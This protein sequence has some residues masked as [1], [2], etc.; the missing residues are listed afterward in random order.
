MAHLL[1]VESWVGAMSRLL[2]R[3]I[4]EA[5]HEFTFLTRDLDHYL[6]SWHGPGQ[7][8]LL[9]AKAVLTAETNDPATVLAAVE[10]AHRHTPFDGV[11]SSCDYYLETA[12]TLARH[13]GL[14]GCDPAAVHRT[15]RK[16]LARGAMADAGMPTPNFATALRWQEA[17]RGAEDIGYPVVVKPVDLCAG[18]YV[19][20]ADDEAQLRAAFDAL[21]GF[22]VNARGQARD[23]TVLLEEY[24]DGPEVS[25][26]TVTVDGETT[27]V[28]VTDKTITGEDSFVEA[29]HAFPAPVP[30]EHRDA[31]IRTA[32]HA[33]VAL[34]VDLAVAHTEIKLTP[35]GPYV[36]EVN[37]RPAGNSITELVRRVT[38]I[39]LPGAYLDVVRGVAPDLAVRD[40]GIGGAAI[41]FVVP[42]RTG[43]VLA[44]RGAD[45]PAD[46][47]VVEW[48]IDATAGGDLVATGDNNGYAGRVMT[49]AGTPR[50]AAALAA[51]LV[52]GI[53][54]DY[55]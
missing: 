28:G 40:T 29:G 47:D 30:A 14:P 5:G 18:M 41:R 19:R 25:V 16:H 4:A 22:P 37:L 52:A 9:G 7:H 10:T 51:E 44:V 15:H 46:A 13:L 42:E 38:G 39:D 43:R 20:R 33:L 34:G 26:E 48:Q 2:P 8:P 49:V 53:G 35:R 54:I 21:A 23:A 12:A 32:L 6:R 27:V 55:A 11:L 1:V 36:V 45:R 17:V 31:A 3:S 50:E 24:L